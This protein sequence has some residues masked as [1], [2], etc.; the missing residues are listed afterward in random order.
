MDEVET[1]SI[2]FKIL[3]EPA[4]PFLKSFNGYLETC[5]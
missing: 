3:V 4:I 5:P 1:V 2:R